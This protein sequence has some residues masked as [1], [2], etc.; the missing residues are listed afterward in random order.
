MFSSGTS[1]IQWRRVSLLS[2]SHRNERRLAT[3]LGVEYLRRAIKPRRRVPLWAF[4]WQSRCSFQAVLRPTPMT[5]PDL[6]W[7]SDRGSPS[8]APHLRRPAYISAT[9]LLSVVQSTIGLS[10]RF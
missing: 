5:L 1:R 6:F 8:P 7:D 4:I 9:V 3:Y 10:F 2:R